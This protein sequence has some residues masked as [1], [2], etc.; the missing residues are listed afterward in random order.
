MKKKKKLRNREGRRQ[1]EG[2]KEKRHT[3]KYT[4]FNIDCSVDTWQRAR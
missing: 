3:T 1:R 2:D 4:D